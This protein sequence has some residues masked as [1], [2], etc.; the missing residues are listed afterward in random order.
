MIDNSCSQNQICKS[1]IYSKEKK[2]KKS[3][4]VIRKFKH[5]NVGVGVLSFGE[6]I[7]RIKAPGANYKGDD[8]VARKL[9]GATT[10]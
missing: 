10:S 3:W 6:R 1:V 4:Q 2:K 8:Q 5:V 9:D 7:D